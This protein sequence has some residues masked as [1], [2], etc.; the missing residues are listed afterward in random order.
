MSTPLI[1]GKK[2]AA[3]A[4]VFECWH[5]QPPSEVAQKAFIKAVQP[6]DDVVVSKCC[7]DFVFGRVPD[8]NASFPPSV[9]EFSKHLERCNIE[10]R[11]AVKAQRQIPK[12]VDTRT[13]EEK[14]RVAEGLA[15]LKEHGPEETARK[16]GFGN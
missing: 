13:P 6:I 16:Y 5:R 12:Q 4:S 15:Y 11:K 8:Q 14:M 3:L 10:Y 9:A 7:E 2:Q 1:S